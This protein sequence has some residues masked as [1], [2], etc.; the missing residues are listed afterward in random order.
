[1][2]G[3]INFPEIFQALV[4]D[5]AR[6]MLFNSL[7]FLLLFV[8]F[9]GG[10]LLV[11]RRVNARIFY[12]LAF[13]CFFYYKCSGWHLGLLLLTTVINFAFGHLIFASTRQRWRVFGLWASVGCSLGIL[14]YFKYSLFF[15]NTLSLAL[16]K[17]FGAVDILLPAGISFYTFQ[18]LS[19]TIDIYRKQIEPL[20]ANARHWREWAKAL[21]DFSFY[22]SF[23]PHRPGSRISPANP[24][25]ASTQPGGF[26]ASTFADYG[27]AL[28]KGGHFGLPQDQFRGPRF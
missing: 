26:C 5:P 14:A 3:Q 19:Y 6:P 23:F 11:L 27:R 28:Q 10:Y 9:Y 16:N 21:M 20:S 18:T 13:S 12:L 8:I 15:L 17:N 7:P 2:E 24:P 25:T 1:M 4:Y 22:V